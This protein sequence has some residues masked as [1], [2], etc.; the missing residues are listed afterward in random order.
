[1]IFV[2]STK[3]TKYQLIAQYKM[4]LAVLK[5]DRFAASRF[6]RQQTNLPQLEELT[7]QLQDQMG[8]KKLFK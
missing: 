6:A 7:Y 8:I 3:L 2:V 4:E 1:M 5:F